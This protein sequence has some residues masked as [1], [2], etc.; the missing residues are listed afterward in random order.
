MAADADADRRRASGCPKGDGRELVAIGG[1]RK[2]SYPLVAMA[3][4]QPAPMVHP[5]STWHVA[6]G[7]QHKLSS[8]QYIMARG[9]IAEVVDEVANT[10]HCTYDEGI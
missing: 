9:S 3:A 2:P 7:V 4:F 8:M 1:I 6:T 10:I 5:H